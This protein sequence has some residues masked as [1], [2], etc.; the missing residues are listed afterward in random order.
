MKEGI[1]IPNR[2]GEKVRI[3]EE[4]DFSTLVFSGFLDC[5]TVCATSLPWLEKIVSETQPNKVKVIFLD[6]SETENPSGL[7]TFST[8]FPHIQR[9]KPDAKERHS[10]LEK[11]RLVRSNTNHHSSRLFIHRA[12]SS[13][14]EWVDRVDSR[15]YTNWPKLRAN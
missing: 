12:G 5:Q 4:D 3:T 13:E 10:V 6:L 7:A 14:A 2:I 11:L 1:E 8:R 15:F 9:V